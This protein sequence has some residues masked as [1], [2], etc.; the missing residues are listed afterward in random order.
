MAGAGADCCQRVGDRKAEI[1]V[2][3]EFEV[4]GRQRRELSD[5]LEGR[6]RVENADRIGQPD[7][8]CAGSRGRLNDAGQMIPIGSRGILAADGNEKPWA[9]ARPTICAMIWSAAP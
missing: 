3:M 5:N 4:D 1:V 9:A 6:K 2:C 7:A 8:A